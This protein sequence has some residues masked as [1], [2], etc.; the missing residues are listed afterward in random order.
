M[1]DLKFKYCEF[2]GRDVDVYVRFRD[3]KPW[4]FRHHIVDNLLQIPSTKA[5]RYIEPGEEFHSP[6]GCYSLISRGAATRLTL[7]FGDDP[8]CKWFHNIL[9]SIDLH[10]AEQRKASLP[11]N[12][13]NPEKLIGLFKTAASTLENL[14]RIRKEK[15][16]LVQ[17]E[18]VTLDKLLDTFRLLNSD[19]AVLR[20]QKEEGWSFS[21]LCDELEEKS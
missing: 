8:T 19:S 20:D 5:D 15:E 12:L 21:K 13:D 9:G 6:F 7:M 3:G 18:S 2:N 1:V 16:R 10:L 4:F 14:Q 17:E 11:L